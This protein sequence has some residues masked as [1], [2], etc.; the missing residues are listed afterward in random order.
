MASLKERPIRLWLPQSCATC[1]HFDGDVHCAIIG[2]RLIVGGI[3]DPTR[4]V[5]DLHG[6][7]EP[8]DIEGAAV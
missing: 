6:V 3:A 4:V 8:D 2:L 1:R 5:C 7:K